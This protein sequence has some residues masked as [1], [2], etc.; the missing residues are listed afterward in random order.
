MAKLI[1]VTNVSLDGYIEDAH[2]RFD[3]TEPADEVF[4]FIS[5][6]VRP[7][8]TYLYGRRLYETMSAWEV[9]PALAAQSELRA[10][11]AGIWQ[12]ADKVVYSTTSESALT[13]RTRFEP[14]FDARSVRELK[15][16]SPTDLTIGGATL[17]SR[18]FDAHLVDECHLFVHPVLVGGGM[19]AF[20]GR[21]PL[22]L[23]LIDEHQ[24][25]NGVVYLR[26]RVPD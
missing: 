18:A 19:P 21:A 2:G 10:D 12:S 23:D 24:F 8:G 1:Y 7:I 6:L 14:S 11:F 13:A 25:T 26:Y 22:Q 3:W 5:D 20:P 4:A 16:A 9:E 17:A 15:A